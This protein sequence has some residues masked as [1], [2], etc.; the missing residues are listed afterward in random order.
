MAH[1]IIFPADSPFIRVCEGCQYATT[2]R[3]ARPK[4]SVV[5]KCNLNPE[6][7]LA[8]HDFTIAP[9]RKCEETVRR[10]QK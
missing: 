10:Q 8:N 3:D 6:K 2:I 1:T 5:F 9:C 4:G 7:C